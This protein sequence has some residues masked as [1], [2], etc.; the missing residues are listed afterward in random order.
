MTLG[1]L[2]TGGIHVLPPAFDPALLLALFEAERGTLMLSVP[3]MLIRLLDHPDARTRDLTSWRLA[4]L[5]GAPV[6]PEL[7]RRA[8]EEVGLKVT[9]G[10]GQTE[11][12]PLHHPYRAGRPP[13]PTGSK[14]SGAPCLRPR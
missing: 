10:F 3:T 8:A 7:A 6:P 13:I 5:G 1:A 2:Q 9:I 4:A 11:A 12:S 14:R